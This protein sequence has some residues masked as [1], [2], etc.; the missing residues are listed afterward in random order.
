MAKG[1]RVAVEAQ[2]LA[3]A[4]GD[5]E[6]AGNLA[7]AHKL[8]AGNLQALADM[9]LRGDAAGVQGRGCKPEGRLYRSF[10]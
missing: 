8:T 3:G 10:A 9:D 5:G 2:A 4:D 6:E 1:R 7:G